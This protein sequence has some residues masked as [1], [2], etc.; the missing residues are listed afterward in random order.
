MLKSIKFI[1]VLSTGNSFCNLNIS[2]INLNKSIISL[3]D[4]NNHDFWVKKKKYIDLN[5]D[6]DLY[7]NKELIDLLK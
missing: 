4:S 3:R 2:T 7:L 5:I 6:K 1:L